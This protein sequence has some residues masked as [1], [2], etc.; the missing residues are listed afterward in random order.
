MKPNYLLCDG[1]Q[2]AQLSCW[3]LAAIFFSKNNCQNR[4]YR[5]DAFKLSCIGNFFIRLIFPFL[6]LGQQ[7]MSM[8]VN[9]SIIWWMLSLIFSGSIASASMSCLIIAMSCFLF[10][11]AKNPKY[12]ILQK[13]FGRTW[14]KNRRMNSWALRVI[15]LIWFFFLRSL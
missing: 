5:Y 3:A 6:H 7:Q 8:P 12:R 13:P 10:L 9:R 2:R 4:W 14:S 1:S 11:W 15:C